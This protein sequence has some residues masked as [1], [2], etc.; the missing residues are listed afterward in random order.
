MAVPDPRDRPSDQAG[1]PR[2]ALR[3]WAPVAALV[4]I[5]VLFFA[6]GLARYVSFA[7]LRDNRAALTELVAAHAVVAALLFIAAYVVVVAASLPVGSPLTV[8]GGFLF[9]SWLG[10]LCVLIGATAGATVLFLAAR[11]AIGDSVQRRLGALGQRLARDLAR[12][13]LSYL[14]VLRL[15]P[16]FPFWLVNLVAAAANISLVTYVVGT[17]LGIIP[18]SFVYASIGSGLGALFDRGE[19]PDLKVIFSPDVLVPIIGLAVLALIPV[20][21]RRVK[22]A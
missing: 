17:F 7:A 14:L 1:A 2:S 22:R 13:A 3:R 11:T 12:N 20:V 8:L 16:V 15:V 6:F 5:L 21:Y 10:T 19:T 18:A 4:V 9:G